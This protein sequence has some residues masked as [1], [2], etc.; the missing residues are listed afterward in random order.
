MKSFFKN[1]GPYD[2]N[3]IIKNTQFCEKKKFKNKKIKNI[4]NLKDSTKGDITFFDNYKYI[5]ELK[6]T[7]ASYCII[8]KDFLNHL[9]NECNPIISSEPL[10]DFILISKLFYPDAD[11]DHYKFKVNSKFK[12]LFK[13]KNTFVESTVKIGKNFN[14][15]F[16]T[17]LKKN[18]I[19]GNNVSIGSN[20]VISNSIIGDNVIINDGSIIGKI[21]YGFKYIGNK[22]HF[23]PHLGCV[24]I[25]KN[26][27]IGSKCTIDRG[28][29]SNT[30]IG[31]GTLIDN[32][33]HI[34]HN[35]KIGSFCFIAG[36]VGIAGST[37][38][39]D[40]CMIGGQAGISGHLKIGN[41]VNIGG[42]SGVLDD[43][44]DGSKVIG[45]PSVPIRDFLKNRRKNND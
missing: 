19:I 32:Q 1:H 29:F 27:Y 37:I 31:N 17:T 8:K 43:L 21:G 39:G 3:K 2:I 7:K 14:V 41:N 6:K 45:F 28:S 11:K 34:A 22:L 33:V 16:N 24:D 12:K 9:N 4:N 30:M 15:G 18:V 25:S 5:D 20:C 42:H 35:V 23:I 38:I 26:V 40:K 13:E 10:L 36:Q 44:K